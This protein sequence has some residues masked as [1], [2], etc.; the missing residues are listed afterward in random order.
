[1]KILAINASPRGQK[2]QTLKLVQAVLDGAK[3]EG[4]DVELVDVCKLDIK[5]CNGCQVCYKT[6][7]CTKK[8]DFQVLYQKILE[9]DGIVTGAPNYLRSITA[10]LKTL[11]D[12]MADAIHCQ[13]L[14][15]KYSVN[16]GTAGG[17][18]YD[19]VTEYMNAIMLNFGSFVTGSVGVGMSQGPEAFEDALKRAF[20]MGKALARD[21]KTKRD[22][23]EQREML[24]ENRKYFMALVKRNKAE[25]E[26]E[27]EYW[28][29]IN[30]T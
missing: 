1:M 18:H 28:N 25:W 26:H 23:I 30:W 6:G 14:T 7:E 3:S 16:V 20:E 22:Y 15:G 19:Q 11:L 5:Y 17:P 10:Q 9:A 13:L 27:Y 21:I 24:E 4:A 8:D 2:S 29:K 12:R